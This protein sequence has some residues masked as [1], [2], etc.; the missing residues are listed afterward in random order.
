MRLF[1]TLA[2]LA[3]V[4]DEQI[5][6][7]GGLSH[8]MGLACKPSPSTERATIVRLAACRGGR[9][10]AEHL[11]LA[12][13]SEFF[14]RLADTARRTARDGVVKVLRPSAAETV[15]RRKGMPVRIGASASGSSG[16]PVDEAVERAARGR[17]A[18]VAIVNR[19]ATAFGDAIVSVVAF[20]ELR[21]RLEARLGTVR[22]DL[23]EHPDNLEAEEMLLG[24][25]V[26]DEI[27][28]LPMSLADF[29]T[30]HAYVDLVRGHEQVDLCWS[31]YLLDALGMDHR[32]VPDHRKRNAIRVDEGARLR[33][34]ELLGSVRVSG[35]PILLFHPE[36]STR[37][38]SIP[39]DVSLRLVRSLLEATD[40]TIV[41]TSRVGVDHPRVHDLSGSTPAFSDLVAL[42]EACDAFVC[43]DTCVYHVADAV[44]VP[45]VVLFT[46]VEPWK[47]LRY[48]PGVRGFT[49]GGSRSP[50][51]GRHYSAREQDF[52]TAA[53]LWSAFDGSA[54]AAALTEAAASAEGL[55]S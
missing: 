28:H 3:L 20:R 35:R 6:G 50:L 44:D 10:S 17:P 2:P 19:Y 5:H 11:Y 29:G 53:R 48:Y 39:E 32:S 21:R 4:F 26:I 43:A 25:G 38:R 22:L 1:Y 23:L 33:V 14:A 51:L 36:A 9:V 27:R 40:Y 13:T 31:D 42:V 54:L 30:Y 55:A 41:T 7:P 16:M 24:S 15:L 46:S 18:R 52:A 12:L 34:A 8:R 45:G 49:V 47:R 37:I